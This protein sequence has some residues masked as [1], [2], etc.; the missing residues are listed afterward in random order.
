MASRD[1]P[2]SSQLHGYIDDFVE[3]LEV[4]K[5]E[6][7]FNPKT[8]DLL[9]LDKEIKRLKLGLK[10]ALE[11]EIKQLKLDFQGKIQKLRKNT[12]CSFFVSY[13]TIF[14][15]QIKI[16]FYLFDFYSL[17]EVIGDHELIFDKRNFESL[18]FHEQTKLL[19]MA[20][21]RGY[22]H[23][24]ENLDS[25]S[26]EKFLKGGSKVTGDPASSSTT[27]SSRTSTSTGE[28]PKEVCLFFCFLIPSSCPMSF[29]SEPASSTFFPF[30]FFLPR[31]LS[32]ISLSFSLQARVLIFCFLQPLSFCPTSF[33]RES[34][35][36]L[37][38]SRFIL[39]LS[40]LF[41]SPSRPASFSV[42]Y[43]PCI[44]FFF[45]MASRDEPNSPRCGRSSIF[46]LKSFS[47]FS[48][49]TPST[50]SLEVIEEIATKHLVNAKV[51]ILDFEILMVLPSAPCED[52]ELNFDK[53][54]FESL[55]FHEQTKVLTS[56][57]SRGYKLSLENLDSSSDE[58]GSKV[59]GD[60][61]SSSTTA[62]S[63]TSTSTSET[64]KEARV[65]IF[66]FLHPLSF[67][68]TSFA[69]ESVFFL[70]PSRFI[71][72]L[73]FLFLSP[74]RPA[75]FSVFCIPCICFF[76]M[77]SRDEPNS[78]Q[79]HG[80][81]DDFV[82][83]V[84]VEKIE[85]Y[86]NPKTE[87]LPQRLH[88]AL[89]QET[90]KNEKAALH[91][92]MKD[93][94]DKEIKRLKLGLKDLPSAPCEDYELIFHKRSFESL[95]FHEQTKL[96]TSAVS[97]GYKL[98]LENLD[99]SSDEGGSK[100][101]GDLASLSTTASSSTSTSTSTSTGETPKEDMDSPIIMLRHVIIISPSNRTFFSD[102][103]VCCLLVFLI[104]FFH[105]SF[106]SFQLHGYIDDFVEGV[107]VEKIEKD[108]NPKTEDLPQRL[109]LALSQETN[110]LKLKAEVRS[111][112]ILLLQ[113]QQL[114]QAQAQARV[115]PQR[116]T[117]VS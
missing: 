27:A 15:L 99:S 109:Q 10:D 83:G 65:L 51:K 44:L 18:P 105:F 47:I 92:G 13:V 116:R 1:E 89:S 40:F 55:P 61:A 52:Y 30:S 106:F 98:S 54:S 86:F 6:K 80:Y 100:V 62:S 72:F 4:E 22:K 88:L 97:R 114:L 45:L 110:K 104:R 69:R 112:E 16:F 66:C 117:S 79:L 57:V 42:F 74:S 82:E 11:K 95:P 107:D 2:N 46:R 70:P 108:F 5:I 37:P 26:D 94:V 63:S 68:P 14:Y 23:S 67:C 60:S 91:H 56:A 25:S 73:S 29:A 33:V 75:S 50:K 39:F 101:T 103:Y 87:D 35:L 12:C 85:K 38:P 77:A 24:L 93:A 81:I 102:F 20:V 8:E 28:T 90:N 111:Q 43:I 115:K 84:E 71:L 49:S 19:T 32:F 58:G 78:L 41:L 31:H 113:A 21:S 9:Q 48:T 7:D 17:E 64:P 3:G 96:L 53:R 76:L 36:F 59:T 34:V